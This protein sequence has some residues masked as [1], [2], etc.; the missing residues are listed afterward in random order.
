VPPPDAARARD[1]LSR[2]QAS[3]QAALRDS[4]NGRTDAGEQT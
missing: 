1:A 2:Y 3:R 4:R